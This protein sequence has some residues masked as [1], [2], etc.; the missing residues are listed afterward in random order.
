M[1]EHGFNILMVMDA[2]GNEW[3][4]ISYCNY[5]GNSGGWER[6]RYSLHI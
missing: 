4:E 5:N 6:R 2:G 3:E 1:I